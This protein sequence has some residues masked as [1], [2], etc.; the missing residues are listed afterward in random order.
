MLPR[1]EIHGRTYI[2]IHEAVRESGLS[3]S[4]LGRLVRREVLT[5]QIISGTWVFDREHLRAFI[6]QRAKNGSVKP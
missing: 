1:L 5:G 3:Q 6:A 4:Y 2:P